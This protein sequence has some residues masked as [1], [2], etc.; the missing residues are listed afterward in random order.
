MLDSHPGPVDPAIA[1]FPAVLLRARP[2]A[3][4]GAT[5]TSFPAYA[6]ALDELTATFDD[7]HLGISADPRAKARY[8]WS[9][10]WPG[11]VT[12]LRDGKHV[13]AM[14]SP[15][16]PPAGT[17]LVGCDGQT[18]DQLF[19]DRIGRFVGRWMLRSRR[20]AQSGLRR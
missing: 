5:T 11:F 14:A 20:Q 10:R 19:A 18:A 6:A 4:Q 7:G 16:T 13:A 1:A 9:H 3:G 17:T 8:A 12:N 15:G 2:C